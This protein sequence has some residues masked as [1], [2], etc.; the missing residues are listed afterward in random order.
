M[1][2]TIVME[3]DGENNYGKI[4]LPMLQAMSKELWLKVLKLIS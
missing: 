2:A 4:L 1:F 3:L